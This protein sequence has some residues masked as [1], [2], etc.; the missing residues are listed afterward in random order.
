MSLQ[1]AQEQLQNALVTTFLANLS[2]LSEY[3]NELYHRV[4]ELSRMI[5]RGDYEEKYALEFIQEEG[6]FDIYDMVN[7]RYLYHKT[8]KKIN[9]KLINE[10]QFDTKKSIFALADIYH[11]Y[12]DIKKV[13]SEIRYN[14]TYLE[15]ATCLTLYD[16]SEYTSILKGDLDLKK[17]KV[18]NIEKFI[19][20]GTLLGRHIPRIAQKID[21]SSYLVCERNLEIF[22]LSLFTVDY[23]ILAQKGVVF[24]IMDSEENETKKVRHF[25][26]QDFL[27]NSIFK[28]SST[29][30]NVA[31]YIENFLQNNLSYQP[32]TYD[33]NRYLYTFIKRTT[34]RISENHKMLLSNKTK[35][36]FS[37]F[38]DKKILYVAAGPSLDENLE[39][40]KENQDK[41]FIVAIGAIYEKLLDL[42]IK[43]DMISTLDE[44]YHIVGTNHF[45]EEA[46]KKI[47]DSMILASTLT[48]EDI[49]KRFDK[50]KLFFFEVLK[51][52][53]KN[54]II[55]QG[56][57]VGEITLG[58]LL[59][60]N[61]KE[62]Y[63]VGLDFSVNPKT[64]ETHSSSSSSNFNKYNLE[65]QKN[66]SFEESKKNFGEKSIL[67]VKGNK[68]EKVFT[69]GVF[70]NSILFMSNH[71]VNFKNKDTEIY[72]LSSSGAYFEKTI[73]IDTKDIDTKQFFSC[74]YDKKDL[75][76]S[77]E[78]CS[79][80]KLP[81]ESK[82]LIVNELENLTKYLEKEFLEFG[83]KEN[84]DYDE[85]YRD[86]VKLY[87]GLFKITSK[88]T[89]ILFY[90]LENYFKM[91]VNYLSL[92]FNNPKIKKEKE[93]IK[94]IKKI[95]SRQLK[96]LIE[97]YIK[98]MGDID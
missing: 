5:E 51:P 70:S 44:Q 97:D 64:G 69:T 65:L 46:T 8:P 40:I 80:S 14:L 62:V 49:L 73:P 10:V 67:E 78:K 21:A 48:N 90:C 18:K 39:W 87:E 84:E 89:G 75:V 83:E 50:E 63:L 7:N 72:N 25:I 81:K 47:K 60:M 2:F 88:N 96:L 22:R 71:I 1:Q 95:F 55:V 23:T 28:F 79:L 45:R 3:D 74:N 98:F 77:L 35:E 76:E 31:E 86:L 56:F 16:I 42:D 66:I 59:L 94:K 32:T 91:M 6:D 30:I 43:V 11:E 4:D 9:N 26:E 68:K 29:S 85:F 37:F 82:E 54:N 20:F 38:E 15:E 93:K 41:F 13:P 12:K 92:Y 36:K 17:R 58:L 53:F 57:S 19:F 61:A 34:Q 52:F 27:K 33:Y 24:S